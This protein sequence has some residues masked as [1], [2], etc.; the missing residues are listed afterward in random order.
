MKSI[1]IGN[2]INQHNIFIT[3]CSLF[4]FQ[5]CFD[6][7]ICMFII[8]HRIFQGDASNSDFWEGKPKEDNF[9]VKMA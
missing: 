3:E 6:F 7:A 9:C 5:F 1:I 2:L 8:L 4:T